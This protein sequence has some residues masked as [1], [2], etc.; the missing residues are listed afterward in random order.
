MSAGHRAKEDVFDVTLA[1]PLG[2]PAHGWGEVAAA[3]ERG[4]SQFRDGENVDFENIERHV[5]PDLAYV[6]EIER[7]KI[8]GGEDVAPIALRVTMIFRAGEGEWKVVHRR[9]DPITTAQP[10]E[11]V[12]QQSVSG[13]KILRTSPRKPAILG[14]VIR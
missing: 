1:N 13:R 9:A 4:A 8:G 5:T 14:I 11:S 2:P 7:A 6:L 3:I 10:A 12:I